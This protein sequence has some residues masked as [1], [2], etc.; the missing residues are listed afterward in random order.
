MPDKELAA[1]LEYLFGPGIEEWRAV[2]R[3]REKQTNHPRCP[4]CKGENTQRAVFLPTLR[5][6]NGCGHHFLAGA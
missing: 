2:Q 1:Q 4:K 6:C 5:R 3:L